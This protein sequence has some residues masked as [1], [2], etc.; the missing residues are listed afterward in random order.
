MKSLLRVCAI[1]TITC[2]PAL[3]L[4]G[5][6]PKD[7][8][9]YPVETLKPR[10]DKPDDGDNGKDPDNGGNQGGGEE[11]ALK[12]KSFIV[13]G[14]VHYCEERFYDLPLMLQESESD[15]RQITQTYAPVTQTNW[16]DQV[17]ALKEQAEKTLPP[18]EGIIQL[19]DISEG[20]GNFSGAPDA[21]AKNVIG[22]LKETGM[23]APWILV[24][25]N[26]DITNKGNTASGEAKKAFTAHY[27]PFI[28]SETGVTDVTDATYCIEKDGILIVVL[29]AYN[30]SQNQTAY[31]DKTLKA[32][33]AKFKF[34][35]MHDPAIPVSEKCWHYLRT[36]PSDR[37]AFLKVLAE[38]K[39]FMLAG[40][41]HRYSVIR[42]NTDYGPI[43]QIMANSVT[44]VKRTESTKTIE[45]YTA[46][47]YGDAIIKEK[48]VT[49]QTVIDY[50]TEE[51]KYV[52]YYKMNSLA[53]YG[54]LTIDAATETLW[55]RYYSAFNT[56]TPY[57]EINL[58]ELYSKPIN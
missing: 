8:S 1:F 33:R 19:G 18:V 36:K 37:A 15:H 28:K 52:D 10:P 20:L 24:K 4:T 27:T 31:L 46:G 3:F 47:T 17:K 30:S 12:S 50:L 35:C 29:D 9:E 58:T 6:T 40:H 56:V 16:P 49:N 25:G 45:S 34:V 26:H 42:R 39:A 11:A 14:D 22:K 41:L 32:S 13:I 23:P 53:G 55:L 5:C 51:Q 44:N 2:F 57:D 7:W 54:I 48:N 38:N 21:M 43:V